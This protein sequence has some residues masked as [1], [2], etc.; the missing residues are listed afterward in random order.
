MAADR[1]FFP[2]ALWFI[3]VSSNDEDLNDYCEIRKISASLGSSV[4]LPCN[5]TTKKKLDEVSW[6]QSSGEDLVKLSS[7]RRVTFLDPRNGRVKAFPNQGLKGNYS[8]CIDD[9]QDSDLGL[10]LCKKGDVCLK[11]DLGLGTLSEEALQLIYICVGVVAAFILLSAF[12]YCCMKCT[13]LCNDKGEDYIN[14]PAGS[15]N[16][17]ASA[18]PME[19]SRGPVPVDEQQRGADNLVYENDDHDPAYMQEDSA[20]NNSNLPGFVHYLD[21]IQPTQSASSIYPILNE[22]NTERTDSE[23]TKQRFHRELFS[24]LRQASLG[25][26]SQQYYVNQS[27]LSKQQAA[28]SKVEKQHR[29]VRKKK[30]KENCEYKNPIYNSSTDRVNQL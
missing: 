7:E 5:F 10:Y 21:G 3:C 19:P 15:G 6:V 13:S 9:L 11:V 28:S 24:R 27:E 2:L 12:G 25:R 16:E 22:F 4:L 18:P 29:G 20:R 30:T 8:I 1:W 17:G 14:Y 23:I 26:R